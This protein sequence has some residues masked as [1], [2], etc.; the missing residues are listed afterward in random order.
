MRESTK[1]DEETSE[2][3]KTNEKVH[4]SKIATSR[5][6]IKWKEKENEILETTGDFVKTIEKDLRMDGSRTSLEGSEKSSPVFATHKVKA[7]FKMT[8]LRE[9]AYTSFHRIEFTSKNT[10]VEYHPCKRPKNGT[11]HKFNFRRKEV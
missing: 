6:H 7:N 1:K 2:T 11:N 4:V 10:I 5:T 3:W 9:F 8:F